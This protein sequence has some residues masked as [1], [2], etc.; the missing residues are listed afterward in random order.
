MTI[1]IILFIL[2]LLGFFGRRVLPTFPATGGWIHT[3]IVIV[4]ILVI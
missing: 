1:I 3:M 4:L 2:W